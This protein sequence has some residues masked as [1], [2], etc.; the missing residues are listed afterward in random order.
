M[1]VGI[2]QVVLSRYRLDRT[3]PPVDPWIIDQI[4]KHGQIKPVIV[5]KL[6]QSKYEIL[7]N[8]ESWLCVQQAGLHSVEIV[9]RE[10]ISD[11]DAKEIVNSRYLGDPIAEAERFRACLQSKGQRLSIADLARSLRRTRTYVSHSL[12]LLTL[13]SEIQDGLKIGA[14]KVGHAKA[15]LSVTG[16][17]D[18]HRMATHII[19]GRWSVRRAEHEARVLGAGDRSVKTK[20]S[21]SYSTLSLERTVSEIV[22]SP[23]DIDE[24]GG[25][26]TIDYRGKL[27]VL[28]GLLERLGYRRP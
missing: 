23:V 11:A 24:S 9:I 6:S 7:A 16:Y 19:Q 22:G 17:E 12:R 20:A 15:I 10:G 27:D 1:I 5:R 25:K 26:L 3:I 8:A 21:K 28:N 4:R 14:L 2:E 13:S 18:R